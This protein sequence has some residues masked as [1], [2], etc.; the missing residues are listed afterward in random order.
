MRRLLRVGDVVDKDAIFGARR[1]TTTAIV[2]SGIRCIITYLLI[3]ILAPFI[4]IFETIDPPLA[5]TLSSLAVVMG[6]TGVRRFWIAD[7]R[8]RWLY[9]VFVAV[10]MV[11]LGAGIGLD[12]RTML[13]G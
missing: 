4:G 3:P 2:V 10:A 1:S 5:I 12:L 9:A 11:L 7:H 13:S 6:I 8:S